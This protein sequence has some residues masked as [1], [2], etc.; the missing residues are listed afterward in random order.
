MEARFPDP[1]KHLVQ[2]KEPR[3]LFSWVQTELLLWSSSEQ[4]HALETL[5]THSR[6]SKLPAGSGHSAWGTVCPNFGYRSRHQPHCWQGSAPRGNQKMIPLEREGDAEMQMQPWMRLADLALHEKSQ[7][8]SRPASS[9]EN[10]SKE[11]KSN[12]RMPQNWKWLLA[13]EHATV[14]KGCRKIQAPPLEDTVL[15]VP[16]CWWHTESHRGSVAAVR[17]PDT[18]LTQTPPQF[19]HSDLPLPFLP[20]HNPCAAP[21]GIRWE[22]HRCHS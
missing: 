21:M 2:G 15:A 6:R 9:R 16:H 14:A 8:S 20:L 11:E 3:P 10:T 1:Q 5:F 13:K 12:T 22:E 19:E 18:T 4:T 7:H 17:T